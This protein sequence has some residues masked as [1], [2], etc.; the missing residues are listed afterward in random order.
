M[1][2]Q[3]LGFRAEE[4]TAAVFVRVPV[5]AARKLDQASVD[6]RRP[7]RH[8]VTELLYALEPDQAGVTVGRY[9]FRSAE[10]EVLTLEEAAALLRVEPD[11][12]VELAERRRIPGRKLGGAWRFSRRALLDWLAGA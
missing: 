3:P 12:L 4:E 9:S 10:E 2:K 7:K 11:A 6:L 8:I 5:S 1:S